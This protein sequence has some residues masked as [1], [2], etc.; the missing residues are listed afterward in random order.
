ME[1][2]ENVYILKGS[3]AEEQA[4]KEIEKIKQYFK[5]VEILKNKNNID[6]YQGVKHLAYEIRKEKT[7]YF[8]IT[9]FK[10]TISNV[11][12][13]EKQLKLNEN[14]IKWVTVRI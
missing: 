2:F 11:M 3:L 7:G 1:K 9:Y 13:I 12:N 5:D 6:G 8:Y 10:G 14:V 4:K